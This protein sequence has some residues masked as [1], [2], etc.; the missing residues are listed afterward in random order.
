ML[1]RRMNTNIVF[2][3]DDIPVKGVGNLSEVVWRTRRVG[4]RTL[5]SARPFAVL[6]SVAQAITVKVRAVS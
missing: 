3:I 6:T 1:R 4:R 5:P 2:A